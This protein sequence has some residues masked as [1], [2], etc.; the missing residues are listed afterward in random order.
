M[1][2]EKW[3]YLIDA[4]FK[5]TD[6]CCYVMKKKPFHDFEK[7]YDKKPLLGT[8]ADESKQ[9]E[10]KWLKQ[11][12]NAFDENSPQS[13]PM[14][15]WTEQDVLQYLLITRLPYCSVY[16][17][18]V[19]DNEGQTELFETA[20]NYHCTGCQR[21]GCMFCMFGVHLE[22]EPNR[23][24]RMKITHPKQYDYCINNLGLGKVLDYINVK[25]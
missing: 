20:K 11:G 10:T 12:C 7:E 1:L 14:S 17:D 3:R 23:F 22:K 13:T 15:F 18:I 5:V 25:Y 24:Q 6:R 16:G 19:T 4:P 21:T 2:P 9:R 8:M